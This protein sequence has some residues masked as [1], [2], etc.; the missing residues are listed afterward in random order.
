MIGSLRKEDSRLQ[1]VALYSDARRVSSPLPARFGI[2]LD[3][4]AA[5]HQTPHEYT[6]QLPISF[7]GSSLPLTRR[8]SRLKFSLNPVIPTVY[9]SQ[10]RSRSYNVV[11]VDFLHLGG[12]FGL[13][14]I[15]STSIDLLKSLVTVRR[16]LISFHQNDDIVHFRSFQSI[17]RIAYALDMVMTSFR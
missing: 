17:V 3:S 13:V 11:L 16:I 6:R 5:K 15:F 9:T 12:P 7:L 10:S 1:E 4:Q 2:D 8:G 14:M